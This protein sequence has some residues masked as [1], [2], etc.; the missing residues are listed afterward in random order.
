MNRIGLIVVGALLAAD[1]RRLAR[2]SS[3]TSAR[4]AWSTRWARS[5][6]S[7]PSRA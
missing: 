6:K 3:S 2:C 5:R 7:S 1:D 4:S